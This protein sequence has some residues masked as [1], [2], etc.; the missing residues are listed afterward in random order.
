[1]AEKRIYNVNLLLHWN[2]NS[3]ITKNIN[4]PFPCRKVV[5]KPVIHN[6]TDNGAG[7]GPTPY[8]FIRIT[9]N[10]VSDN[11]GEGTVGVILPI[12]YSTGGNH[13]LSGFTYMFDSPRIVSGSFRFNSMQLDGTA[14]P[15]AYDSFICMEFY[16]A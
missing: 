5:I 9:S 7:G 6:F 2:T 12:V 10:L 16:E 13:S 15:L 8:E 11:L 3:S 1:M 14:D 4:V